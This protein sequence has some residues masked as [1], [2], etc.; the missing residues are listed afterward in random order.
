MDPIPPSFYDLERRRLENTIDLDLA[1][2]S[3]SSLHSTASSSSQPYYQTA[4]QEYQDH[5]FLSSSSSDLSLEYPRAESIR[6]SAHHVS[7]VGYGYGQGP[8]GTPRAPQSM[9]SRMG[10]LDAQS[11]F[12]GSSPVSTAGH[13]A[14]A[15]TLGAGVFGGHAGRHGKE[16]EPEGHYDSERSMGKLVGELGRVMGAKNMPSRPDSPFSPRSPSPLPSATSQPL[17]LSYTLSRNDQL[18]SPPSSRE[19]TMDSR[20]VDLDSKSHFTSF[21]RQISGD[22]RAARQAEQ[23]PAPKSKPKRQPLGASNIDN[24]SRT[25]GPRKTTGKEKPD[26]VRALQT[27]GRRSASAPVMRKEVSADITGLSGLLATPAAGHKYGGISRDGDVGGEPAVNIP[28]TLATL[29][30]RL[31]ALETENSVSRRRVKELEEE[32]EAAK[33]AVDAAKRSGD[34]NVKEAVYEKSALE[35]LI[36][37]LRDNLARLTVEVEHNKALVADLRQTASNDRPGPSS[38]SSSVQSELAALRMEI[39]RLTREVERL[40]G[41]VTSGLET[42]KRARGER[43]VRMEEA[44]MEKLVRQVVEAEHEEIRRAQADVERRQAELVAQ[45][46][47]KPPRPNTA[48]TFQQPRDISQIS[49]NPTPPPSDDGYDSPTASRPGSRQTLV[50]PTPEHR[51]QERKSKSKRNKS[52]LAYED[53]SGGPGSPFPSINDEELEKEFF[54]PSS[55]PTKSRTKAYDVSGLGEILLNGGHDD[56]LPPQTVLAR[57]IA[58]L[59]D[60]FKHYKSIYSELADQYKV[61]DPAS[62]SAKRHVLADH[63]RE[64]IDTLEQKADQ[65]SELY[66]LLVFSDKTL[67]AGERRERNKQGVKSVGDVLRMVKRS[68][69]EEVWARLQR[70]FKRDS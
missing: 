50:A 17:N 31:R 39:E 11:V 25:P 63:L 9:T 5:T 47:A 61:L 13:H 38:Q 43:T 65:I 29:H 16:N 46:K 55:K 28:H 35:E 18:L 12:A 34:K 51:P 22:L 1:S 14:S 7:G 45:Q 32:L 68:L 66:S 48:S 8:S 57:V 64:V 36:R 62:V 33:K 24:I 6:P 60:D 44:E 41:I 42:Q 49:Q 15:M 23:V 4:P 52:K 56:E 69:G 2:L 3:L 40:G 20:P 58:E 10:S 53:R 26:R 70:D 37:S 54:S 21:A 59:E 19:K 67:S 30:A 27:E